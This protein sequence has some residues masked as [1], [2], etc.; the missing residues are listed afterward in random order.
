MRALA[1]TRSLA[2]IAALA[3]T[4]PVQ[5]L[6]PAP[7]SETLFM[8]VEMSDAVVLARFRLASS[9]TGSFTAEEV[10]RGSAGQEVDVRIPEGQTFGDLQPGRRYLLMLDSRADGAFTL[11]LEGLSIL[12]VS[13]AELPETLSAVR[14]WVRAGEDL[15]GRRATLLRFAT[16]H[17]PSLQRSAI[18]GF[19]HLQLM[20]RPS[21]QSLVDQLAAGRV[22]QP[23]ARQLIVR[24]T[25]VMG[26]TEHQSFLTS[27]I[28]DRFETQELREA[29]LFALHTMNPRA[30]SALA[31]EIENGAIPGL[32]ALMRSLMH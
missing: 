22:V 30:S 1:R 23:E 29:S 5:A 14:A 9:D 4:A 7:G 13:D 20:D 27:R 16:A 15:A 8:H 12:R 3:W 10:L 25:G 28:R 17:A 26:A 11:P 19:M 18:M 31:P 2:L 24:F 32:S 6:T 21:L